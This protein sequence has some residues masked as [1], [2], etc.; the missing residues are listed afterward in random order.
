MIE[1]LIHSVLT[2]GLEWYT[3]D[4]RRLEKY[5]IDNKGLTTAEAALVREYFEDSPPSIIMGYPRQS[6][7]FPCWCIV[8]ANDSTKQ[9]F[10]GDDIDPE[11]DSDE[12]D[13]TNADGD[14]AEGRAF[15][16]NYRYDIFVYAM[17]NPDIC[18]YN[19]YL[20]RQIML[21]EVDAFHQ[22]DLHN[23]EYNGAE[24]APDPRFEPEPMWARR[25]SVTLDGLEVAWM[26]K[27]V[28]S[29]LGGAYWD[30]GEQVDV[31]ANV[32]TYSE[33]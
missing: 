23:I 12:P 19:Y 8:L 15:V 33:E 24:L 3:D 11:Y 28:G 18:L 2:T 32:R 9:K 4:L 30:D 31:D 14:P 26:L 16:A 20:L 21:R 10:I 29:G 1:R 27:A 6:G 7:P 17:H 22:N 13:Y 5:F 25:L